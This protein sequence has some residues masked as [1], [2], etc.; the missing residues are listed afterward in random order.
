M[1][2]GRILFGI[3]AYPA[4][5]EFF[6]F[7]APLC[8]LDFGAVFSS[9]LEPLSATFTAHGMHKKQEETTKDSPYFG[10][11]WTK[12][13][14]LTRFNDWPLS[15]L[16][17][18]RHRKKNR[19]KKGWKYDFSRLD[20]V[21]LGIFNLSVFFSF[22][23]SFST[24]IVCLSNCLRLLKIPFGSRSNRIALISANLGAV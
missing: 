18:L 11:C 3:H 12:G 13:S 4:I 19:G 16:M 8:D 24:A 15:S 6:A 2:L 21:C 17:L 10:F 1:Q 22:M 9:H 23:A 7:F 5:L 20:L 14:P